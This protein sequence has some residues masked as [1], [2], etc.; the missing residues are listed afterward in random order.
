MAQ[1][2]PVYTP[3]ATL[4]PRYEALY[5]RYCQLDDLLAPWFRANGL[6]EE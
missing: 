2:G 4:A 6:D 5:T 3:N 1:L